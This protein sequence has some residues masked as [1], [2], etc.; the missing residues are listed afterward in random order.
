M[1]GTDKH[2]DFLDIIRLIASIFVLLIHCPIDGMM[3]VYN[4]DWTFCSSVFYPRIW[5]FL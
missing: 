3:G 2:Y 4:C 5:I 1:N